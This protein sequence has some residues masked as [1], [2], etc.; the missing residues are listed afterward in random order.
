[1]KLYQVIVVALL[2][3]CASIQTGDEQ[4]CALQPNDRAW[5]DRSVKGWLVT[6]THL[7][8][9]EAPAAQDAIVFDEHCE[10]R[11]AEA[12]LT[13]QSRWTSYMLAGTSIQVGAQKLRVGVVSATVG[14]KDGARFVMSVPSV[15]EKANVPPGN[16]GLENLMSA[17][18]MHEATHVFQMN[19]Y[20]KKIESLQTANRLSDEQF[21]DDAIQNRFRREPEFAQSIE[22][23]T[24]L[25]FAAAS[26]RDVA[27]ALRLARSARAMMTA[28]AAKYYISDQAYQTSAED[29]WLT[30]EGSAQWA[31]FRWLQLPSAQRGA[32]ASE[33]DAMRGFGKRGKSW[34]QLLGLAITL[35]VD[36]LDDQSWKRR[37]F[38]DGKRTILQILDQAI[39]RNPSPLQRPASPSPQR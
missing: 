6:R 20:G 5:L 32:G 31:G 37:V 30:M 4:A 11:S 8:S 34:T 1:M 27:E 21:N 7:L 28:R 19:T 38:G 25:F 2:S 23:E 24:E 39:A 16:L 9:A 18:M 35:T 10:L 22:R 3:G 13:G 29:L 33:A 26:A 12:M 14:D 15:W 36:R 17:V